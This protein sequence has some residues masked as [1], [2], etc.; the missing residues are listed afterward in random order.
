MQRQGKD[1]GMKTYSATDVGMVRKINQDYVYVSE[2]PLGNLPNLFVVA[3]G[4]GGHQEGDY[5][6]KFTV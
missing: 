4:I 2:K 5:A 1:D 3:D 6:S